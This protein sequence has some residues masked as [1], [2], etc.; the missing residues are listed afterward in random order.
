MI[1]IRRWARSSVYVETIG[2]A[3]F[4]GC[5]ELLREIIVDHGLTWKAYFDHSCLDYPICVLF[6]IA[7]RRI[8]LRHRCG[9]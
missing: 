5:S 7:Y 4:M 3:G 9:R 6:L 8:T 2:Y 1:G